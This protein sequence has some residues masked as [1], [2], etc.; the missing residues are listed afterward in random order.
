MWSRLHP[1]PPDSNRP[2]PA[3]SLSPQRTR[4][5]CRVV[6]VAPTLSD[7]N[8]PYLLHALAPQGQSPRTDIRPTFGSLNANSTT[9]QPLSNPA[10]TIGNLNPPTTVLHPLFG[11]VQAKPSSNSLPTAAPSLRKMDGHSLALGSSDADSAIP[12]PRY[13]HHQPQLNH[14][15]SPATTQPRPNHATTPQ[16][17]YLRSRRQM[18]RDLILPAIPLC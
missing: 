15:N 12:Q 4:H 2:R 8:C 9:T 5:I 14:N 1:T 17:G 18:C 16:D 11:L 3:S 13:W 10:P 6:V 7:S